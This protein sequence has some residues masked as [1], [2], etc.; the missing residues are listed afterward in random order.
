MTEDEHIYM[1]EIEEI[2]FLSKLK[3]KRF[4]NIC[5]SVNSNYIFYYDCLFSQIS[6]LSRKS[7]MAWNENVFK[8]FP[9]QPENTKEIP[10][11]QKFSWNN[12]CF[13][14]KEIVS[15]LEQNCL[16]ND[17]K[18]FNQ[19][20]KKVIKRI[21]DYFE[22]KSP[23]LKFSTS[24]ANFLS[25]KTFKEINFKNRNNNKIFLSLEQIFKNL[26]T[27]SKYLINEIDIEVQNIDYYLNN[28]LINI[29]FSE[30]FSSIKIEDE[31]VL[32]FNK[33]NDFI[34]SKIDFYLEKIIDSKLSSM[35]SL[36]LHLK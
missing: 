4:V 11:F 2:I 7:V 33:I 21:N 28:Y 27:L 32:I 17:N 19:K 30:K 18:F 35:E 3:N 22:L 36:N 34:I 25:Q 12:A 5:S 15:L 13:N 26:D 14:S 24:G 20:V 6:K 10:N 1:L 29:L 9:M 8:S 31:T 23:D 16:Q